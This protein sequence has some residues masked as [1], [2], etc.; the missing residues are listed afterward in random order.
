MHSWISTEGSA[1]TAW[2]RA[3]IAL[4]AT[5]GLLAPTAPRAAAAAPQSVPSSFVVEGSGFGHGIGMSQYG[6]YEMA[7]RGTGAG[8]ILRHY[9]RGAA[10]TNRTT[11]KL[12]NVQVYGPDPGSSP[13]YGDT[14]AT[15]ITVHGSWQVRAQHR[16]LLSGD[17][18]KLRVW[19]S[20]SQ[21]VVRA[22]GRNVKRDR[23]HLSWA[24]TSAYRP[25]AKPATVEIDGTHGTYRHGRMVLTESGG[26]PNIVNRLRLNSQY[27]YGIAE[28]PAS[29]GTS[30]G[31][32]ALRA[33]AIVARSYAELKAKRWN[34][35]CA[36]N[37]VD[38][39]RDQQFSGWTHESGAAGGVW[40]A[41]VD[42]TRSS[43]TKANVLTYDGKLVAAHYFSSSG[44]RTANSEDVW[45]S[46]VPYERSVADPYSAAA[47]GNGYVRWGRLLGQK[48]AQK[49]FGLKQVAS[50]KVTDRYSSG[51][52]RT[53]VANSPSG[54]T[55]TISG[56]ADQIRVKVGART[57]AGS[58]PSAWITRVRAS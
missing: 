46:R 48:N 57:A 31:Q 28:M 19:A 27:L 11:H 17:G 13:S 7:R 29:W 12:I 9:Y 40:R 38:D 15:T 23:L 5:L 51:Q 26:V 33:Q 24:G 32:Q 54:R 56:K 49:L 39:V 8:G 14:D 10:V 42:A 50:I 25:N 30:G 37:L 6:A 4:L 44:G 18:G 16:T 20:G 2:R 45:L 55:A 35:D 3:L 21:V 36:C 47:P 22:G 34:P 43:A 53:L 52:A 41:A 58:V 1:R